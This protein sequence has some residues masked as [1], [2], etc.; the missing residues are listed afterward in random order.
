MLDKKKWRK[1]QGREIVRAGD[2]LLA[3][4]AYKTVYADGTIGTKVIDFHGMATFYRK[5]KAQPCKTK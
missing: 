5:R 1:M 2:R 4:G 3:V